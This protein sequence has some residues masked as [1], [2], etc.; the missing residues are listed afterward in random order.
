[1]AD[2]TEIRAVSDKM[3]ANLER[4]A[5]LE[6]AK[7]AMTVGTDEFVAAAQEVETLSRLVFRWSGLQMQLA[8]ESKQ[9]VSSGQIPAIPLVDVH[10]RPLDR[11]LALW[12]EAQI[13]LEIAHPGSPEA[14][15]AAE[16]I[17]RLRE[18]YHATTDAKLAEPD[19]D[20]R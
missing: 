8:A 18:E 3:L 16:D 5:A 4:L 12:R 9:A 17:E 2:E 7:R 20:G 19:D 11:V 15:S 13:R 10:P 14:Q 6:H 1:M